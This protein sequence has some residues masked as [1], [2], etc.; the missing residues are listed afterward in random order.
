MLKVII[1]VI[2]AITILIKSIDGYDFNRK[3]RP[4]I[5]IKKKTRIIDGTP[6][7]N[8]QWPFVVSIQNEE[9]HVCGG[10]IINQRYVLTACHCFVEGDDVLKEEDVMITV[11]NVIWREGERHT[12]EKIITHENYDSDAVINDIALARVKKPFI[13]NSNVQPIKPSPT[14]IDD[15]RLPVSATVVGWGFTN[16]GKKLVN[17]ASEILNYVQLKT[18]P[19]YT[20]REYY[21]DIYPTNLC[22]TSGSMKGSCNGDSG[23]PLVT[24]TDK[25]LVQI[26]LVSYGDDC[27]NTKPEVYTRVPLYLD[28]IEDNMIM[29]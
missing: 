1:F 23:G 18:I 19:W 28:W 24:Y 15:D 20:C 21:S 9:Q 10:A 7:I 27:N 16:S 26:G 4:L 5:K 22:M 12:V 2:F 6:A 29:D 13:F 14:N 11:G 25:G 8:G 17:V 3:N